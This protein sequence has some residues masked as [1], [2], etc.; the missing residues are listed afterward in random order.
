MTKILMVLAL[1]AAADEVFAVLSYMQDK[2]Q[3]VKL[4]TSTAGSSA[5]LELSGLESAA[6][7]AAAEIKR[8]LKINNCRIWHEQIVRGADA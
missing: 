8:G 1:P 6:Q 2:H 5:L 3:D 7:D 4:S